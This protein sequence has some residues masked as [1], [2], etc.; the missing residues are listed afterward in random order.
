MPDLAVEVR[1]PSTWRFDVGVKRTAYE[2]HGLPE[3]WLVDTAA[4]AVMV[5]RRSAPG[6]RGFDVA[7]EVAGGQRLESPLLLGFSIA[8]GELFPA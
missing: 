3:L 5:F 6:A 4:G 7:L 8:A 2:Q 1:S